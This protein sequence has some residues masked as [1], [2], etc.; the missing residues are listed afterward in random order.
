MGFVKLFKKNSLYIAWGTAILA[1]LG[2]LYFRE[3]LNFPPCTLCWYQRIAMYPLVTIL[4]VAIYRKDKHVSM[5]VIPLTIIGTLI[6]VYQNLLYYGFLPESDIA[7]LSGISC[8][9]KYIEWLGFITIPLLSFISFML[10]NA[11]MMA[12][13]TN[14]KG[15]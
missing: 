7:C 4:P 12:D 10:I 11:S 6:A 2:S 15:E 1:T 9:S 8:T 3:V 13:Y 5:Y 14:R